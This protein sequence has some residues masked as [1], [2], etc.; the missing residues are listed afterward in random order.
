MKE[1]LRQ[2]LRIFRVDVLLFTLYAKIALAVTKKLTALKNAV[3]GFLTRLFPR[4][5]KKVCAKS[6]AVDTT[7]TV[8]ANA[9]V[10]RTKNTAVATVTNAPVTATATATATVTIATP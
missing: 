7:A 2:V 5:G 8:T 10:D 9:V 4:N 1:K 6:T 3:Q